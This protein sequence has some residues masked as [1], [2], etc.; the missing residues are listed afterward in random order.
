LPAKA[1]ALGSI[2]G[3]STARKTAAATTATTTAVAEPAAGDAGVDTRSNSSDGWAHPAGQSEPLDA[4]PDVKALGVTQLVV[5]AR[6]P[7]CETDLQS[8]VAPNGDPWPPQSGYIDGFPLANQGEE[9]Q[10]L[11]DNS[12]NP[13]PVLVK[14]Y[15]LERRSNVRHAYVMGRAKFLIDKLAAGKYE[16]RYQNILLGGARTDCVNGKRVL[17]QAAAPHPDA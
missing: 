5:P 1:S 9:M 13:S 16:V 12:N 14:I 10:L 8:Q 6:Q 3:G 4:P 15:D 17:R 11:V 7:D 2:L